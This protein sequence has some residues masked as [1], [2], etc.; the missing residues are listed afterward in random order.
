MA[1]GLLQQPLSTLT[2][3]FVSK[4]VNIFRHIFRHSG[5]HPLVR[6]IGIIFGMKT[7]QKSPSI[8]T[9]TAA[10]PEQRNYP[11][12]MGSQPRRREIGPPRRQERMAAFDLVG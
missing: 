9:V 3:E 4:N 8:P 5:Y 10:R 6:K 12:E 11:G 1:T 2:Q 7:D